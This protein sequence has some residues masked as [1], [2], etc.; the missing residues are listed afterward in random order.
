M[1]GAR[2]DINVSFYPLLIFQKVKKQSQLHFWP[3]DISRLDFEFSQ[4]SPPPRTLVTH[5]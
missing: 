4:F 2:F 3:P 1:H 5:E